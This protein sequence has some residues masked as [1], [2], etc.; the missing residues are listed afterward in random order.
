[1]KSLKI[2]SFL[3]V[4]CLS[5]ICIQAQDSANKPGKITLSVIVPSEIIDLDAAQISN[6]KSKVSQIVT[7]SGLSASS[8][9]NRFQVI[10]GFII[11]QTQVAEA[12]LKKVTTAD[13]E[14]TLTLTQSDGKVTYQTVSKN[15]QGFGSDKKQAITKA[16]TSIPVND[17]ALKEFI[18]NG[19]DEIVRYYEE[20][21]KD[22]ISK[23]DVLTRAQNY[24]G[25]INVLI[26]IPEEVSCYNE[27][28]EK[29]LEAYYAYQNQ[30]CAKM[31]LKAQAA[32]TGRNY[33][34]ALD[35]LSEID[36]SSSC[37]DQAQT[38]LIELGPKVEA[39]HNKEL[40][41]ALMMYK[42]EIALENK[43]IESVRD[44]GVAYGSKENNSTINLIK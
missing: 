8:F 43:R 1:M 32:I 26:S 5:F 16:I 12:G 30:N 34:L 18:K 7:A 23:A 24:Q 36:P 40:E 27:A 20:K 31:I 6:L 17:P 22:I 10:P 11:T 15:L 9:Q 4:S 33:D 42:D 29:T 39:Q 28:F 14:F 21:C 13:C 35:V 2:V 25:A 41:L 19:K 38:M 3:L 37:A 44:I